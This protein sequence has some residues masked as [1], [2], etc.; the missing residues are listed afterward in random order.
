VSAFGC[1]NQL[2]HFLRA[3]EPILHAL[4]IGTESFRGQLRR[5][6]RFRKPGILGHES[7]FVH[8]DSAAGVF[9]EISFQAVAERATL[10]AGFHE[11]PDE[12]RKLLAFDAR[13]KAD[14]GDSS[15][16]E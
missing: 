12:V 13:L 14:A 9:P 16:I 3:A 6:S 2:N 1:G 7:N 5:H 10:R 4:A 15:G 11:R 8:A